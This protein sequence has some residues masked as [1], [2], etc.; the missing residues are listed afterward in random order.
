MSFIRLIPLVF[1]A[2]CASCA[3]M[4]ALDAATGRF[5]TPYTEPKGGHVARL[6]AMTHG[7][8]RLVPNSNCVDW[9]KP[10]AGSIGSRNSGLLNDKTFNDRRL[11][12]PTDVPQQAASEVY[13]A[14]EQPLVLASTE[15]NQYIYISFTPAPGADYEFKPFCGRNKCSATLSRVVASGPGSSIVL[16]PVPFHRVDTCKRSN[17]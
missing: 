1:A 16:T 7:T 10:G 3:S 8:I 6:R 5:G 2:F 13:I 12:I 11:G 15:G 17:A 14:A 9:T 4:D